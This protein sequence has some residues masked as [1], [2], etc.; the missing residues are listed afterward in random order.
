MLAAATPREGR[1]YQFASGLLPEGVHRQMMAGIAGVPTHD[2]IG[3]L[4]RFGR[5][6]AGALVITEGDLIHD[7]AG[8]V[9]LRHWVRTLS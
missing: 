5:D 7:E 4:A 2:V 9:F 1:G 8:A 3:M 6:V